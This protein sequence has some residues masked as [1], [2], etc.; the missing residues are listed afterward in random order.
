MLLRVKH[1]QFV[2]APLVAVWAASVDLMRQPEW[3]PN[4]RSVDALAPGPVAPGMRYRLHTRAGVQRIP[5][6]VEIIEMDPMR[7][8]TYR[9][10]LPDAEVHNTGSDR[11]G[12]R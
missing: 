1:E 4:V 12:R 3:Q 10:D 11:T 5:V 9:M 7:M 8:I 2:R 6:D